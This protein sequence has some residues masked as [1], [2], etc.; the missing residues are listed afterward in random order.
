M[1]LY[2]ITNLTVPTFTAKNIIVIGPAISELKYVHKIRWTVR[3]GV[4][5]PFLM[6][7]SCNF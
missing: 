2:F 5:G 7:R 1:V 3:H 6:V 4:V